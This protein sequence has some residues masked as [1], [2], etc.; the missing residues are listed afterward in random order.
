MPQDRYKTKT[1]NSWDK[2][3]RK[4]S[5]DQDYIPDWTWPLPNSNSHTVQQMFTYNDKFNYIFLVCTP[6]S[7]A[8]SETKS[9][10]KTVADNPCWQQVTANSSSFCPKKWG[11]STLQTKKWGTGTLIPRNNAYAC[12]VNCKYACTEWA[13]RLHPVNQSQSLNI[14]VY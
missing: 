14:N 10:P 8:G 4:T 5:R 1:F 13:E 9:R 7:P 3:L 6:Q 2:T 11:Y 12:H